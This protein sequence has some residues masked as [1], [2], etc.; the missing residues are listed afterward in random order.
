MKKSILALS[1]LLLAVSASAHVIV[2]T[3]LKEG[4][5]KA[6]LFVNTIE[7]T[8][9]VKVDKVFNLK[10]ED[11]YGN[12]AYRIWVDVNLS[13]N[14]VERKL[15]VKHKRSYELINLFT[16]GDKTEVRDYEYFSKDGLITLT[17]KTDGR[18]NGVTFLYNNKQRITCS[19]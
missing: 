8:C 14:D 5:L 1:S 7:S 15:K 4:T 18:L 9:K 16:V 2:G 11:S 12:P 13:G 10:E 6:K 19:F 17:M 3:P